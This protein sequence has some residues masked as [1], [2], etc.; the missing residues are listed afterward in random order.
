VSAQTA[1][2]IGGTGPTGP[3][4]V[5]GLLAQGFTTAILHTGRHE[6][7]TIPPQVEHI[8]TNPFKIDELAA[9]VGDR[10]FDIVYSMYGRLRD[11]APWFVGKTGKFVAVGGMPSYLGFAVPDL[12]WPPGLLVPTR[13]DAPRSGVAENEKTAKMVASEDFVFEHHPTATIF[14]YPLIY[15]PGQILPR[16]WLVV[17]RVLDG[18]RRMIV[19]DG[20]LTLRTAGYGPNVGHALALVADH[21]R[22]SAG[23]TYNVADEHCLTGAQTITVLAEALDVEIDLVSMPAALATPARPFLSAEHTLHQQMGVDTI[24]F[25]L[26]YRDV[27][28]A[29]EALG[30]TARYLR[31][32]P[33]ARGSIKEQRLQDPFDYEAE[34]ALIQTYRSATAGALQL[35]DAYDPEF[36]NRYAPGSD[37]WRLVEAKN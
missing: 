17:R 30:I 24:R 2:V 25:E 21:Q 35:A 8:H 14:R 12:L 37:D 6:V 34:D 31:D 10:T 29:V 13:E 19:A 33:V 5:N 11:I 28:P 3:S 16:E 20:G 4:L 9:A 18:R 36:R 15:G 27:T 22:I 1:L 23:R 32:H 7:D 26:G